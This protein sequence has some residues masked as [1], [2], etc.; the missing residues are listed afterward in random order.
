MVD[1]LMVSRGAMNVWGLLGDQKNVNDYLFYS[2][3]A[4][5]DLQATTSDN[6]TF[7]LAPNVSVYANAATTNDIAYWISGDDGNKWMEAITL[8]ER[9]TD[10]TETGAAFTFSV[11]AWNEFECKI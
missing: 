2:E 1:N 10:G 11:D 5:A 4:L 9:T 6:R 8:W 7:E 3:W